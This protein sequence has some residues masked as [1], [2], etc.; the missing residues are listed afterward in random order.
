MRLQNYSEKQF[1]KELLRII[2]RHLDLAE[3]QVFIFGSRV[4]GKGDERSDIDIGIEGK[5]KISLSTL[6]QIRDE[7]EGLP[8]LYAVDVVDFQRVEPDFK[9]V[10]MAKI[11]KLN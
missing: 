6:A 10:A 8:I 1:K 2:G 7:V 4:T 5:T 9:K 3:H 11:E